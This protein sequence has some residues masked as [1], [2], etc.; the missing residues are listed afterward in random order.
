MTIALLRVPGTENSGVAR[1]FSA[2]APAAFAASIADAIASGPLR[3]LRPQ[4]IKLAQLRYDL[5]NL[6]VN[7]EK[8]PRGCGH[9]VR[10]PSDNRRSASH[11]AG[12]ASNIQ[13]A[14]ARFQTSGVD[15]QRHPGVED[16]PSGVALVQFG[17]LP[18]QLPLL[19][20]IHR[21]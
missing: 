19:E 14:L 3:E 1:K 17:R 13:H 4:I 21:A 20:P 5:L 15:K 7:V 16:V 12:P 9:D 10:V 18:G 2:L 11:N 6:R 8:R